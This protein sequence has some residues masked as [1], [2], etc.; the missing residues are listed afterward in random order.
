MVFKTGKL[1]VLDTEDEGNSFASVEDIPGYRAIAQQGYNDVVAFCEANL[2]RPSL[3]LQAIDTLATSKV[4]YNEDE[5][6]VA[7]YGWKIQEILGRG[8]DGTTGWGYKYGDPEQAMHVVKVLTGYSA[9]WNNNTRIYN[10][11]LRDLQQRGKKR[12]PMLFD[13]VVKDNIHHYRCERP[14]THISK[15][16]KMQAQ[17]LSEVCSMNEWNIYY[18]GFVFWDLG[19]SNGRN[20]MVDEKR[21]LKWVDYGGA[22]MLRTERFKD[23]YKSL[24]G[25]PVD[26]LTEPPKGKGSLLH[27]NSDFIMMQFLLN[28]E[29]WDGNPT[30]DVWSSMMQVKAEIIPE[31]RAVFPNLLH[32]K[33]AKNIWTQYKKSNWCDD[34]HWRSLRKFINANT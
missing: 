34:V 22:G 23:I 18:T 3:C 30:A 15:N 24:E 32:S 20:Y 21:R 13:Q 19:Y 2:A 28:I 16:E 6:L 9:L 31:I 10:A 12:H 25:M 7:A 1:K 27:A 5:E 11:M 8:K 26:T 17:Y 14:F 33:L 4:V 29:F